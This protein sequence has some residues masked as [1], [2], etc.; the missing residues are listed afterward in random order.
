MSVGVVVPIITSE[1]HEKRQGIFR[2]HETI[3]SFGEVSDP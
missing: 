3:L 2:F 1:R